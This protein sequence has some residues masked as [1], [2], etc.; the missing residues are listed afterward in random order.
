M[1]SRLGCQDW[2]RQE[3]PDRDR[4]QPSRRRHQRDQGRD[5]IRHARRRRRSRQRSPSRWPARSRPARRFRRLSS[6]HEDRITKA[7]VASSA[8]HLLAATGTGPADGE[9]DPVILPD[10]VPVRSTNRAGPRASEVAGLEVVRACARSARAVVRRPRR[11]GARGVRSQRRWEEHAREDARRAR[12]AG[13]GCHPPRRRRAVASQPTRRPGARDRT[14]EPGAQPRAR[15]ERR[16]QHLPRRS[17][18]PAALPASSSL[19]AR[20]T[21]ARPA[22]TWPHTAH[23]GRD[24]D[25]RAAAHR[26]RTTPQATPVCSSSTSPL[27]R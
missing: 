2:A 26:D 19:R 5:R 6:T 9:R 23:G 11:R 7:N 25:R 14:R 24:A 20:A 12:A 10:P 8:V 13:R 4:E 27:R 1:L 21:R 3:G 17:R 18:R 15:A 16:G 22:R